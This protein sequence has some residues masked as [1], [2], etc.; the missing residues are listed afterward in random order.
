MAVMEGTMKNIVLLLAGWAGIVGAADYY[1][2]PAGCD[3][4]DGSSTH[5]WRT[6]QRAADVAEAGDVVTIRAGVYRE[7]VRP[8]HAGRAAAPIVYQAAEGEKVVVT[9][10]DPVT[11]W[12]KRPDGLWC[13]KVSYHTFR[14]LNPFTDVIF[15]NWFGANGK[16]H[17]RTRLVQ[18]GKP[19]ELH[20]NEIFQQGVDA[21]GQCL[22]NV[23]GLTTG[24]RTLPGDSTVR[25]T[26]PRPGYETPWGLEIGWITEGATCVYEGLDLSTPAARELELHYSVKDYPTFVD[27]C[28]ASAH[29]NVLATV[30][31]PVTGSW[32]KY[33]TVKT[34]L[35]AAA[36][37]V[38][39]LLL[40]FRFAEDTGAKQAPGQAA[41]VPGM[42]TGTIYA[43]FE[44]DPN[45]AVPELVTRP[46]CFYPTV[47]FRDYI[48]LRGIAF[49]NAG[50]NWA[51]PTSE[52]VGVVGTNWSRGW[53]IEDCTVSGSSCT[54]ITLGKYGDEYD[55]FSDDSQRYTATISRAVANGLDRVG[56]HTVRRCRIADCGQAGICGSLGAVFSTVED[57]EISY[58]H[59]QKPFGGAEMAG[60]KIHGAVDFTV[61]R[62]RI[63][64]C[65]DMG[66][67]WFD[68]M[69]QGARVKNCIFWENS[70]DLFCEVDHGPVLVEGCDLL[71]D[72][73]LLA[74]SQSLAFVACRIRG[75]LQAKDDGRRSPIFKPH[76]VVVDA[77]DTEAC[78]AGVFVFINNI[79]AEIPEFPQCKYPSRFEDNAILPRANWTVDAEKGAVTLTP[80]AG[81]QQPDYRLVTPDRLGTSLVVKQP[82]PTPTVSTPAR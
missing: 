72:R 34:T 39:D 57:C 13:A 67:V 23:A 60:I 59:W 16:R 22:I 31:A 37:G 42:V 76:T 40:R 53:T 74:W 24:T 43:A 10:A 20:G 3:E 78:L 21:G 32:T 73:A 69:A 29:R 28:D 52:Q 11:G 36:A 26:G 41:L 58:C 5:P 62:C 50:P 66:G 51:P 9:G 48:T 14:G 54:G 1:V 70:W 2:S 44:Q 56:H 63:H 7:W 45:E 82:Y 19:L 38:K 15:G 25:R 46:A 65:G 81:W 30:R 80:P 49:E 12:T 35:P 18:N 27:F 8:A 61:Q 17:F 33:A 55:N 68:W 77:L 64:H 6:I 4:A 75:A 71:S 79:M 47:E